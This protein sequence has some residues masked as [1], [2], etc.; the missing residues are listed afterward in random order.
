MRCKDVEDPVRSD[1]NVALVV[2]EPAVAPGF[3]MGAAW[4]YGLELV[5]AKD[6]FLVVVLG[7][8]S[9]LFALALLISSAKVPAAV[10]AEDQGIDV[11]ELFDEGGWEPVEDLPTARLTRSPRHGGLF[12]KSFVGV[13]GL[14]TEALIGSWSVN[15]DGEQTTAVLPSEDPEAVV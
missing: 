1:L 3:G 9:D 10:L 13:T 4:D 14:L 11:K 8:V 6:D 5:E 2:V 12:A 7:L 15:V